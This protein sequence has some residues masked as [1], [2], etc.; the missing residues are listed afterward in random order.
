[1]KPQYNTFEEAEKALVKNNHLKNREITDNI[2]DKTYII[3]SMII[4]PNVFSE[5]GK[6]ITTGFDIAVFFKN[7]MSFILLKE[8]ANR[9]SLHA[10]QTKFPVPVLI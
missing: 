3:S 9:F 2:S 6:E 8:I 5:N 1:M 4:F 10:N 7:D